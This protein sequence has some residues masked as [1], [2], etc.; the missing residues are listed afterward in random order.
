MDA[1]DRLR[2]RELEL[3][4]QL[5]RLDAD[6]A[7][8]RVDRSDATADDEHD[9]EGSTLSGEWQ[10]VDALRASTRDELA[11]VATALARVDAGT[12]GV[13]ERCG[14]EIPAARMEVR[15]Q[16]T[17]CVACASVG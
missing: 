17:M 12:Y 1:V 9:P 5:S 6:D 10:R 15:P 4:A 3:R 16:A 14:R 11:Q 2:A 8:L 7:A 13:C